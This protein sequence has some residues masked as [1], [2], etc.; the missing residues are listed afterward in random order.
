MTCIAM[1][2]TA[3]QWKTLKTQD[4]NGLDMRTLFY[5]IEKRTLLKVKELEVQWGTRRN[6]GGKDKAKPGMNSLGIRFSALRK[7][8][9]AMKHSEVDIH[10]MIAKHTGDSEAGAQS[11]LTGYFGGKPKV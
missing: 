11:T 9:V 10:N 2:I 1:A 7:K 5:D 6:S 4:L 8:L 3:D